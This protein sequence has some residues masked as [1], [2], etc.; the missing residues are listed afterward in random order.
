LNIIPSKL[1]YILEIQTRR[2][3][4]VHAKTKNHAKPMDLEI[5]VDVALVA[6]I[7]LHKPV[8]VQAL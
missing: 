4:N 3:R 5:G 8:D 2:L 1:D 7:V 6:P